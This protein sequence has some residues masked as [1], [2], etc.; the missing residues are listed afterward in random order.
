M[1]ILNLLVKHNLLLFKLAE[2]K[3]FNIEPLVIFKRVF[4]LVQKNLVF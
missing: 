4:D 1:H 2:I 3:L